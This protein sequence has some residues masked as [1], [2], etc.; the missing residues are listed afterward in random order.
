MCW[1]NQSL[2][3]TQLAEWLSGNSVNLVHESWVGE[4]SND[5]VDI[6]LLLLWA[7]SMLGDDQMGSL[8]EDGA[9]FVMDGLV[10][11]G[12][13]DPLLASQMCEIGGSGMASV[14]GK[15]LTLNVRLEVFNV[16]DGRD[17][18]LLH[19]LEWR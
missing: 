12:F 2:L 6:F 13:V 5:F 14:D 15:E 8:L 18:W 11:D 16:V 10:F 3:T 9:D 19:S 4:T 1:G 7:D 17:L